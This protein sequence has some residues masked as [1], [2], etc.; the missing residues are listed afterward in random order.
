[1]IIKGRFE[2]LTRAVYAYYMPEVREVVDRVVAEYPHEVFLQSV[3]P[4]LDGFHEPV[5]EKY[6]EVMG[7]SVVGLERFGYRYIA[8]GS[9]EALFHILAKIKTERPGMALYT[10]E[11]E[12]EGYRGYGENLGL[13]FEVVA[14]DE[15]MEKLGKGVFFV[16]NPSSRDGNKLDEKLVKRIS[17]A[18]HEI[19]MDVAYAGM[20]E[21]LVRVG[22]PGVAW[23][24]GSMSKPYGMYYYRVGFCFS[25]EK[26]LTL[27][28][29]KWFKNIFSLVVA[30]R[31]LSEVDLVAVRKN[32]S[33]MQKE[34]VEEI[35]RKNGSGLRP[36]E[37][38]LLAH[39]YEGELGVKSNTEYKKFWR[40]GKY[41]RFGLTGEMLEREV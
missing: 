9:S 10:L 38:Y 3:S 1:M 32:Y 31:V 15:D 5:I 41:Y 25:R 2:G 8:S 19:V 17:D 24:V 21:G 23:V 7:N 14:D 11:G 28:V 40:G 22:Y 30:K 20:V 39:V 34:I 26:M 16:S 35:N 33:S 12:Y 36:S 6:V 4:G 18:G 27:E 37:V 13:S 29:N